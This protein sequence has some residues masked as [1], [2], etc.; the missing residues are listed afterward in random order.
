[1]IEKS[2]EQLRNEKDAAAALYGKIF[3]DLKSCEARID[4]I[5]GI[6]RARAASK[7]YSDPI[8]DA[9]LAM[10]NGDNMP[11]PSADNPMDAERQ[12]LSRR[13]KILR[14][15]LRMQEQRQ[16]ASVLKLSVAM[17]ADRRAEYK[18]LLADNIKSIMALIRTTANHRA[19]VDAFTD[20][21]LTYSTGL[22][23]M[24]LAPKSDYFGSLDQP[25]SR[26][27]NYLRELE[28][29]GWFTADE[30]AGLIA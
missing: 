27:S 9:A 17:A 5:D 10:L 7:V 8:N 16:R 4:E 2:I 18:A 3:T 20:E 28:Q 19:F 15:A 11:E 24:P 26:I 22:G 21:G 30:L 29:S 25:Y 6:S 13:V 1:M 14:E 12:A 23:F